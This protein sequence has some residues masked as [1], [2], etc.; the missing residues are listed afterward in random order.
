MISAG[1]DADHA[2]SRLDQH[3]AGAEFLGSESQ[4]PIAQQAQPPQGRIR[5]DQHKKCIIEPI[6]SCVG[7]RTASR[8]ISH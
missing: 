4:K 1:A 7:S 2:G 8:P 3:V 6:P 5:G